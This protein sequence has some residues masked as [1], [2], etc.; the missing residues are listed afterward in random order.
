MLDALGIHRSLATS[1]DACGRYGG[2]IGGMKLP[3]FTIRDLLLSTALIAAGIGTFS[4][5]SRTALPVTS[6]ANGL[7]LFLIWFASGPLIFCGLFLPI[8][9]PIL[10]AFLGGIIQVVGK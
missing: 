6:A 2:Y 7:W 5:A 3:Q 4:L 1:D 10:G 9:K 8:K